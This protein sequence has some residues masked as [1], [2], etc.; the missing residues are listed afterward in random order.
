VDDLLASGIATMSDGAVCVFPEGFKNKEGSPL[1]LIVR[2]SDEGFGYP[3]T[4]LAAVR[5]RAQT[6]KATR[7]LYVVGAPQAQHFAMVFAVAR[8][9]GWLTDAT[10]PVHVAFG[11]VLGADRQMFRTRAGATVRLIDLVDAAY[12]RSLE[13]VKDKSPDYPEDEQQ[14]IARA[15]GIAAIKYADLSNDRVKDYVFDLERMVQ[16]E[17]N[18]GP[19]LLYA[20]ARMRSIL[21]KA[22]AEQGLS[23][24]A[25]GAALVFEHVAEK[26]L[27]LQ[28]AQFESA[29]EAV[30]SSLDPHKLC[31]YLYDLSVRFNEFWNQCPVLKAEGEVRASRLDLVATVADA[32][33]VGLSLLGISAPDRM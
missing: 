9:A 12:D 19:Y 23:P 31:T 8:M 32:L 18:T 24:R 25:R 17:G 14:S 20:H 6:L 13:V 2:K 10:R 29:I 5:Y 15:V 30:E 26:R 33:K 3:A 28:L 7:I 21:R 4:D 16:A 11:S 22:L 1:P 27:L